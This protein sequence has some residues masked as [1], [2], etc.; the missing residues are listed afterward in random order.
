LRG[1]LFG[2]WSGRD[3]HQVVLSTT[4]STAA[5]ATMRPG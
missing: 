4:L 2:D 3:R 1:R 5:E